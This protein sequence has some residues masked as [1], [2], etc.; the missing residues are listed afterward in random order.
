MRRSRGMGEG[1]IWTYFL[2]LV[3]HRGEQQQMKRVEVAQNPSP[4]ITS[5]GPASARRHERRF[6]PWLRQGAQTFRVGQNRQLCSGEEQIQ[7]LS[8][9]K[10]P[11][12]ETEQE[13][14]C[15]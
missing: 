14:A 12:E 10:K 2:K 4:A 11:L 7:S 3:Q 5:V 1:T 13:G 9:Q 15:G 6:H 8:M